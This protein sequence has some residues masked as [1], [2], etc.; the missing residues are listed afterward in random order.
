GPVARSSQ[1]GCPACPSGTA[2]GLPLGDA[3]VC[4]PLAL[5]DPPV[6]ALPVGGAEPELLEL[7][8]G[9]AR[10]LLAHLDRGRALVVGQ[11]VPAVPDE[12]LLDPGLLGLGR[13][14][15]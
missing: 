3:A 6:V 8:G 7:P 1:V 2:P 9:R 10:Q 15:A 5:V 4:C 11:P 14:R 13:D 12:L